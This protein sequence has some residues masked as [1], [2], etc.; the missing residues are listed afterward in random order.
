MN[1]KFFAFLTF[2]QTKTLNR[3]NSFKINI[4]TITLI[5]SLLNLGFTVIYLFIY[6]EKQISFFEMLTLENMYLMIQKMVLFCTYL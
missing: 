1:L 2:I 5:Y 6:N 3:C 4:E